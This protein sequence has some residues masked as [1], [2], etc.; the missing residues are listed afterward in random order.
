[1][2]HNC[3]IQY[4]FRYNQG[5]K[6]IPMRAFIR[7]H[8]IH[9]PSELN[10]KSVIETGKMLSVAEIQDIARDTVDQEWS[11]EILME[12][13]ESKKKIKADTTD[14]A[15]RLA[16]LHRTEIAP[17]LDPLY[18]ERRWDIE[19]QGFDYDLTGVI[20]V[21]EKTRKVRDIKGVTRT[22]NQKQA[23][24]SLQLTMYALSI[25]VLDGFVPDVYLDC[26][27]DLKTA[28]KKEIL[29]STRTNEDFDLLLRRI[30]NMDESIKKGV[31]IPAPEGAWFCGPLNC[32]YWPICKYVKH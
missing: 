31:F 8:G 25:N 4:D 14:A 23:D 29:H 32:G 28:P 11:D 12:K 18:A 27:V 3:G 17:E 21:Q 20:D 7:G 22:P 10:M 9:R 19:C 24:E 1:M 2:Y 5:L 26:L 15:V 13:G 30:Q 6:M 16:V